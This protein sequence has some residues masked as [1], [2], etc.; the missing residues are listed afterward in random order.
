MY[1][2]KQEDRMLT[3]IYNASLKLLN[4]SYKAGKIFASFPKSN[5]PLSELELLT[6]PALKLSYRKEIIKKYVAYPKVLPLASTGIM[7]WTVL[8]S[9]DDFNESEKFELEKYFSAV[10]D[11]YDRM[12]SPTGLITLKSID[13]WM[14]GVERGGV[15]I[16]NQAYYAKVLDVLFML[17]DDDIY[18]FKKKRLLRVVRENF[19]GAYVL[20]RKDSPEIRPN[21]FIACFFA[22][23]IFLRAD[24]EKTFDAHLR[25][26]D[27]WLEWGGLRLLS[28]TDLNFDPDR[29]GVSWFFLNNIAAISL[30]RLNERKY[31]PQI[32]QIF[33][34][35]GK[36]IIWQEHTGRPCEVTLTIDKKIKVQGLYG[37]SLA[38]FIYLYRMISPR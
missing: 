35:S 32:S 4:D 19:D 14:K 1:A 10:E 8:N 27:L 33:S 13:S 2:V 23:E 12:L 38:T 26:T 17:T 28:Q 7:A 34:A 3:S 25:E 31:K 22:P 16:E 21:S 30:N 5:E 29:D 37:L 11:Y 15:L 6:V 36:N 24:W 18:H 9:M 20:D